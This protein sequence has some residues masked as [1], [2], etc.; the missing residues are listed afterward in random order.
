MGE[1]LVE[2]YRPVLDTMRQFH[3]DAAQIRCIV[4]PVGSGKTTAAA[5]DICYFLPHMFLEQH[6]IKRTKWVVVRNT[7]TELRD[8]TQETLFEWFPWGQRLK[9]ANEY[10]LHYPNGIAVLILFRSCDRPQDIKKFKSLEITGYWIDESVEVAE[11]VKNMLKTRIGRYPKK[12]PARFGI[13]TTNPPDIE[14]PLY[15]MFKW[16]VPPPGPVPSGE[17]LKKHVGFWQPPR[18]NEANLRPGYYDDLIADYRDSPD[19]ALMYVD[20]K[21]GFIVEGK[22]VYNNFKRKHHV[23]LESLA[24]SMGKLYLGWDNTGLCPACVVVHVPTPMRPQVLR[25]YWSDKMGIVDFTRYV[26][27]QLNMD[28]PGHPSVDH[29]ADP[30]GATRFSKKEGGYTS[31]EELMAGEGV[32]VQASEQNFKARVESVDQSL[33]RIDG[34]LIDPSCTRLINGFVGGYCYPKNAAIMGEYME[35]VLKNRYSHVHDA[36]QYVMVKLFKPV[37]REDARSPLPALRQKKAEAYN[38]HEYGIT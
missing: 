30:A 23:A 18:E 31:N 14:H 2:I 21:P 25:E 26:I 5:W 12:C 16:N 36:L 20:G 34:L 28:F 38:P 19:W 4:G 11:E 8:T 35:N 37:L 22:P 6:G 3:K 1:A 10:M 32:A 29:W 27:A 33:A 7:Y 9:Q 24:W 15:S 17:P 13:E